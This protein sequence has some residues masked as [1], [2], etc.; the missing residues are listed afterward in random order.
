MF[1]LCVCVC[2]CAFFMHQQH[3]SEA[4]FASHQVAAVFCGVFFVVAVVFVRM[5]A[6]K[7]HA[8]QIATDIMRE[9]SAG[10]REIERAHMRVI[11]GNN[12]A[13][14]LQLSNKCRMMCV[15]VCC[16][17]ANPHHVFRSA[18]RDV[19]CKPLLSGRGLAS[20]FRFQLNGM[21]SPHRIR[22]NVVRV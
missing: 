7:P 11:G 20:R 5:N 18:R 14:H 21:R 9:K 12:K 2:V 16:A 15:C 22:I 10:E 8:R 13:A 4:V 1:A 3:K 19:A 17:P 6:V